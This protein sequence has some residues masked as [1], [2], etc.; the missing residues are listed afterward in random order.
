[1]TNRIEL[2]FGVLLLAAA[3]ALTAA[4]DKPLRYG[5]SLVAAGDE[6]PRHGISLV[7]AG[8]KPPRHGISLVAAGDK[9]PPNGMS[10]LA[11]AQAPRGEP[12]PSPAQ[13]APSPTRVLTLAE[14]VR[15]ARERQPQLLQAQAGSRAAGARADQAR[16]GLLPQLTGTAS[17]ARETANFAPRPGLTTT[18]SGTATTSGQTAGSSSFH[19]VNFYSFG[20][21]LSQLIYDFGQTSG[22]WRA[23]QAS[24]EAQR[25]SEHATLFQVT[26]GVQTAFFTARAAKDL[27]G[28]A[29]D[30]LANQDAHLR[31]IEGFVRAGTRP[32]I[33]LAQART[34]RANAAV[35]FINAQNTYETTKA[36]LNQAMGVEAAT[37]YDVA[38]DTLPP[39]DGEEQPLDPLLSEAL[40]HRPDYAAL[41]QQARSQELTLRSVNGG[42]APSLGVSTGITDVGQALDSTTWNWNATVTLTWNI[43]Q[44]GLTRAQSQE[45]EA[46]LDS[47]RAQIATLRQQVRVDVVQAQLAVRANRET[48]SA[49][50]E[51]LVNA[52]ERLRLAEGRYQAGVGNVIELGDAQVA[53][54]TAA[55]QR[56][57][58]EYNLASSRAQLLRAL[59]REVPN[60]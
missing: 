40:G 35:Q 30:N 50:G 41:E 29:R 19:T 23:A 4:G 36:Q 37:D 21:T 45:A 6:P 44:G 10:L 54:T 1:M 55:A 8:D 2:L 46:N 11:A 3:P 26:L 48:L 56:V 58:A 17:Y 32:E 28:V 15:N 38:S 27:V 47:A 12:A 33:D 24:S 52:R 16:S 14:A 53:L 51:A 22:K 31:Q 5:M 18:S 25:D 42:Y 20:A 34:D 49:A 43:F 59:G 60:V 39:V 57:Q 7:A 13:P 9:P